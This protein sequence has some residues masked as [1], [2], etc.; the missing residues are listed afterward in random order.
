M[1]QVCSIRIPQLQSI[2]YPYTSVS[3]YPEYCDSMRIGIPTETSHCTLAACGNQSAT[4]L[5]TLSPQPCSN[6][7]SDREVRST[8]VPPQPPSLSLASS[9]Y[10][11]F[12]TNYDPLWSRL[13]TIGPSLVQLMAPPRPPTLPHFPGLLPTLE[14]CLTMSRFYFLAGPGIPHG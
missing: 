12:P 13:T 1:F 6:H 14:R 2:T 3:W 8:V 7:S 11:V 9:T 5:T 4:G 10:F